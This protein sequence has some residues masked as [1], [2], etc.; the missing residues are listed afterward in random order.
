MADSRCPDVLLAFPTYGNPHPGAA[1]AVWLAPSR[2]LRVQVFES[3]RA[4]LLATGFN[5]AWCRALDLRPHGLRYFAMLHADIEP[6]TG[7]LDLLHAEMEKHGLD[8]VSAV[9]PLKDGRGLTSTALAGDDPFRPLGRLTMRQVAS[10]P[11][12]FTAADTGLPARPLLVNTGCLLVRLGDWS[13]QVCFTIRDRIVPT[14][15][16]WKAESVSE[17]WG[18]SLQAHALGLKVAATTAVRLAHHGEN[19]FTNV[20]P[21]GTCDID[22][23]SLPAGEGV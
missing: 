12:T 14:G 18:F 4:S 17:D 7:W 23:D 20:G 19:E 1:R 8:V 9:V 13:E 6:E 21:W 3:H 10:L 22:P 15:D 11:V 16:G 2:G 5:M